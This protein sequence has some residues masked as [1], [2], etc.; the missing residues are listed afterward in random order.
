MAEVAGRVEYSGEGCVMIDKIHTNLLI[1]YQL[2]RNIH[3]QIYRMQ[4]SNL[5]E[6]ALHKQTSLPRLKFSLSHLYKSTEQRD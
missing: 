1:Y 5:Q 4:R 2:W 3:I 6:V